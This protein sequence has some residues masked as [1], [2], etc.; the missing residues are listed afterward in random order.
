MPSAT[1][2]LFPIAKRNAHVSSHGEGRKTLRRLVLDSGLGGKDGEAWLRWAGRNRLDAVVIPFDLDDST[3]EAL[4][5]RVL[6][7]RARIVAAARR[8]GLSVEEGGRCLSRIVPRRLFFRHRELFRMRDGRRI[9]D[10]NF[11]PT[12]PE[13]IRTLK[14]QARK[15]FRDRQDVEVFHLW[16]DRAADGGWCSCPSCRAFSPAEQ[17]LIAVNAVADVLSEARLEARLSYI[18][19]PYDSL[20]VRPRA[21]LVPVDEPENG[22]AA[23]GGRDEWIFAGRADR[24]YT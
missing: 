8:Y 2:G 23:E 15:R 21:N 24:S 18:S 19:D 14:E 11:C 5:D 12:N 4:S 16:P 22:S 9:A 6:R 1:G 17:A 13:T 20:A 3:I 10:F 7:R